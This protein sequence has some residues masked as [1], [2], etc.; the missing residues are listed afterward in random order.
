MEQ[1]H[2]GGQGLVVSALGLV[3]LGVSQG[4]ALLDR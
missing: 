3:C 4:M 1:R 2:L